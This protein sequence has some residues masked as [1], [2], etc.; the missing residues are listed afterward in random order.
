M[1]ASVQRTDELGSIRFIGAANRLAAKQATS[2]IITV[3]CS[4]IYK[5]LE[6]RERLIGNRSHA[7]ML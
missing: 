4:W 7:H 2:L 5:E 1:R 6:R 3:G